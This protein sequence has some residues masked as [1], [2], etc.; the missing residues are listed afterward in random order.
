[1]IVKREKR[2][3]VWRMHVCIRPLCAG[4]SLLLLSLLLSLL[5]PLLLSLLL[6]RV[7]LLLLLANPLP[8]LYR[9]RCP[10]VSVRHRL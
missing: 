9:R 10:R 6:L 4:L 7:L 2:V 3:H 5:L 1:M 8:L